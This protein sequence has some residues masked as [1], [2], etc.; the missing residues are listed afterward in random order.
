VSAGRIKVL[1]G[2]LR[3]RL[4]IALVTV[5]VAC[6]GG[7][8]CAYG[9]MLDRQQ[10]GWRD[11]TLRVIAHQ[12]LLSLPGDVED[13]SSARPAYRLPD[14]VDA[15]ALDDRLA[16]H[17]PHFQVW[18]R[19]GREGFRSPG[20]PPQ[21]LRADFADGFADT[22]V[23]GQRWRVYSVSDASG[24][25]H[26]QAAWSHRQLDA[27][28]ARWL[29]LS[30]LATAALFV[31]LA[32]PLWLV[33]RWSLRPVTS[34]E[35][36]IRRRQ[37]LDLAPLPAA[38]LPREIA[39]LV[40]SFNQLLKRLDD[41][42]QGERRFIADAAHELRT[43]MAALLAQTQ[44]ALD[45][46]DGAERD[47]ALARLREGVQRSARLAEQLLDLARLDAGAVRERRAA[48]YELVEVVVRDFE[49]AA[50]QRGQRIVLELEPCEIVGDVDMLGIA[51]R[52]L[53]D[54][55]VRY[56]GDGGRIA[57]R[58]GADGAHVRLS[59]ADDGPGVPPSEHAR[60]F[61][62]FYRVPGAPGRG[63]GVGLSLVARIAELHG[64]RIETGGGLNDRGFGVTL[65]FAAAP[66]PPK[67][68][69]APRTSDSADTRSGFLGKAI[70]R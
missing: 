62:R 49:A 61:D 20:S 13:L 46:P 37:G 34:V 63:S 33:V 55:A 21:A 3:G 18:T 65:R 41:A 4:L 2:S 42:L 15:G 69:S 14:G 23:A 52:N 50:R 24:R 29:R 31:L 7:G 38:G 11:S 67:R 40:D 12:I 17:K 66:S 10:T 22:D 39:P 45:A 56:A 70:Q 27:E 16:D 1:P 5:L 35:A 54:N 19:G 60:V 44:L 36:A 47:A 26:V 8:L 6:L 30:L 58:C 53:V 32:G 68:P 57:V 43:P 48:L 64:A 9:A 25:V 59:V 51:L 28:R